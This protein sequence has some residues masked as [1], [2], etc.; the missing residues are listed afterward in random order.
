MSD[1]SNSAN[2]NSWTFLT[3][4]VKGSG[5]ES[6]GPVAES[7]GGPG[8]TEPEQLETKELQKPEFTD[9]LAEHNN[10]PEAPQVTP[11]ENTEDAAVLKEPTLKDPAVENLTCLTPDPEQPS[12]QF[13]GHSESQ[14][15]LNT[16][17]DTFSDSCTHI[18]PPPDSTLH[19]SASQDTE[20]ISQEETSELRKTLKEDLEDKGSEYDGVRRRKVSQP[21]PV[22]HQDDDD[23]EEEGEEETFRPPHRED[24][25][26]FSLN[27]CIFGAIIL[28]GLGTIFFSGVLMDL[29]EEGDVEGKELKDPKL[30]KEWVNLDI[31][32]DTPAGVQPPEILEKLT[33]ESQQ[34]SLLQAQLQEQEGEL[35]AAQLQVEEATKERTRRE[36]LEVENQRMKGELDKLPALQKELEQES[37]K[38]K[39]D[40]EAV[41]VIQQELELL[42]AKVTELS[43]SKDGA[44][45]VSPPSSA[46]MPSAG[47]EKEVQKERKGKKRQEKVSEG[48][49][50]HQKEWKDMKDRKNDKSE[51]VEKLRKERESEEKET[52]KQK[53]VHKEED[54]EWRGKEEKE[55]K[56]GKKQDDGKRWKDGEEKKFKES[57]KG[58]RKDGGKNGGEEGEF[59]DERGKRQRKDSGKRWK[60]GEEEA[61]FKDERGKRQRKDDKKWKNGEEEGEFKEER[62]KRQRKDDKK[63]KNDEED[64]EFTEQRGKREWKENKG[65]KEKPWQ[66]EGGRWETK[67]QKRSGGGAKGDKEW[68]LKDKADEN[69]WKR[70]G[71]VGSNNRKGGKEKN[72]R[73]KD[74][75]ESGEWDGAKERRSPRGEGKTREED[76]EEYPKGRGGNNERKKHEDKHGRG[77]KNE[78]RDEGWKEEK[79]DKGDYQKTGEKWSKKDKSRPKSSEKM[80]HHLYSDR[81]QSKDLMHS[82][83]WA[84]QRERIWHFHGSKE[85]C[86]GVTACAQAEGLTPVGQ[87]DFE[88]LL[89]TY[90]TKVLAPEDRASKTEELNKLVGEFFHDG[91][92]VHDQIPFREFVEDVADILEDMAE[93]EEEDEELEDE[94]EAFAIEAM[95]KFM[96]PDK[97][98]K[99]R[100]KESG[101]NRGPG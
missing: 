5:V 45:D 52:K 9:S 94:M 21:T 8:D 40:L 83:Y 3:S 53:K 56:R 73:K 18:R 72:E 78:E 71:Q 41:P 16:D 100:R 98:N 90:L 44:Q 75:K 25:I 88:A 61:E 29:D 91:V 76:A 77:P 37:E 50:E 2:G 99:E 93:G 69:E 17:S 23:E 10:G 1:N 60:N 101:R 64:N 38:V 33:K 14:P 66:L 22:D 39:K 24:D 48:E 89:I 63:W 31:S 11:L 54:K 35:K 65:K 62:G 74:W 46:E 59:K 51:K 6:L 12:S 67:E 80:T 4:E 84:E 97:G 82:E 92:F 47:H 30:Q 13:D 34:I 55:G 58:E 7:H 86:S 26:G 70:A 87:R 96:L 36:E 81:K 27:K 42:R 15:L 79:R 85:G 28:L 43:Q 32:R 57:M 95:E 49:K 19:S 20:G 68:K